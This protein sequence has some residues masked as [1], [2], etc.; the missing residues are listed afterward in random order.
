MHEGAT[1]NGGAKLMPLL[2]E[3][4]LSAPTP[5]WLAQL[6]LHHGEACCAVLERWDADEDGKAAQRRG[7]ITAFT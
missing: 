7:R 6:L 4:Q 3:E 5:S 2:P 1:T